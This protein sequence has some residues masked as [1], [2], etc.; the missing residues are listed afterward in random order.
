MQWPFFTKA[1]FACRTAMDT[2]GLDAADFCLALMLARAALNP[3][4]FTMI[5]A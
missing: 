2:F 4:D 3:P 5:P 1:A